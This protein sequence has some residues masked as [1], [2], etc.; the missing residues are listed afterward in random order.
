M[1]LI[2]LRFVTVLKHF[3]KTFELYQMLLQLI[4]SAL[5]SYMNV[6][7]KRRNTFDFLHISMV[8]GETLKFSRPESFIFTVFCCHSF[9]NVR[10]SCQ[11]YVQFISFCGKTFYF[12]FVLQNNKLIFIC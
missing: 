10:G 3:F 9:F 1:L 6:F 5:S 8:S 7:H 11:G 4:H 12:E 2:F